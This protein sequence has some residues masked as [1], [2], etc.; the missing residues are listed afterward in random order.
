MLGERERER[1]RNERERLACPC[2]FAGFI[3]HI[4]YSILHTAL[5]V[6]ATLRL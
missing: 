5:Q 3:V 2:A 1:E 6:A 4:T